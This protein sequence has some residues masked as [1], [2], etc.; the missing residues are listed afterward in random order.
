[1]EEITAVELFDMAVELFDMVQLTVKG[2]RN[3]DTGT[4]SLGINIQWT[5]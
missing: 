3:G 2:E 1:M 5:S 4:S